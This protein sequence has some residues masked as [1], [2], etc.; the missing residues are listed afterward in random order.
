VP[1]NGFGVRK[2][3]ERKELHGQMEM[4]GNGSLTVPDPH[5]PLKE[6]LP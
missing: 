6:N 2:T 1:F 4:E 5:F 3:L